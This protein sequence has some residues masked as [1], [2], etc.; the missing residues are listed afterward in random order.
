MMKNNKRTYEAPRTET[1]ELRTEGIVCQSDFDR[2]GYG[3]VRPFSNPVFLL[4]EDPFN[5]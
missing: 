2:S 4:D 5:E 3:T 1:L